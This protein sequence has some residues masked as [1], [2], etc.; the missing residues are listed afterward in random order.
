MD[1]TGGHM[2]TLH[3]SRATDVESQDEDGGLSRR[4]ER[5]IEGKEG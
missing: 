2:K 1:P 4:D 5:E 3:T